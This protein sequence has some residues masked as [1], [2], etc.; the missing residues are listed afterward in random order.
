[1]ESGY[2]DRTRPRV[3]GAHPEG[4]R[5]IRAMSA[6]VLCIATVLAGLGG[7]TGSPVHVAIGAVFALIGIGF[8][9]LDRP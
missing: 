2:H 1:M 7:M 3:A 9:L 8:A 4:I 5:V 6:C